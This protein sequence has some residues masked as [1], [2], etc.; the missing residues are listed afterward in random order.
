MSDSLELV[1]SGYD[2]FAEADI[3]RVLELLSV[4]PK[5]R[6]QPEVLQYG[7]A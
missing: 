7:W 3:P 1:Q 4:R 6:R 5:S 2:A